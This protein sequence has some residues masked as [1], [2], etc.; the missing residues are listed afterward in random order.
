M[1][2]LLKIHAATSSSVLTRLF[3]GYKQSCGKAL[4]IWNSVIMG[5][6]SLSPSILMFFFFKAT[7]K[8]RLRTN[9][10]KQIV[11]LGWKREGV[12]DG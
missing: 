11:G 3:L 12:E 9:E 4:K 2:V 5:V 8:T 10:Y 7:A 1:Y 6:I